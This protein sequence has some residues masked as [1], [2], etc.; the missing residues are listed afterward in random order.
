MIEHAIRQAYL[1]GTNDEGLLYLDSRLRSRHTFI[2]WE[3]E[4]L[5]PIKDT[6]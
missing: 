5:G 1:A 2:E 4:L 3:K 6:L